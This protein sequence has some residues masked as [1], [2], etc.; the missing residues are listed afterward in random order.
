[1]LGCLSQHAIY[2]SYSLSVASKPRGAR[3]RLRRK[4]IECSY[5]FHVVVAK[6][7]MS[8]GGSQ[9]IGAA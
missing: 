6:R 3:R 2:I 1:M 9:A 7:Q 8:K 5:N 4:V